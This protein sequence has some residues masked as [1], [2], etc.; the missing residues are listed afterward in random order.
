MSNELVPAP[1]PPSAP[2]PPDPL[3]TTVLILYGLNALGIFIHFLPLVTVITAYVKRQDAT[4]T[5]YASHFTWII[6]SFWYGLLACLGLGVLLAFA[7]FL[8]WSALL[9]GGLPLW[10]FF[11]A[12]LPLWWAY[13]IIKGAL[14]AAERQPVN[15]P[16]GIV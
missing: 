2:A 6:N 13:R 16:S 12:L 11:T 10:V 15:N 9:F 7:T 8:H 14:R 5:V 4:D 3:R 1:V